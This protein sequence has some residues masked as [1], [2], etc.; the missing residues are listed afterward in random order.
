[1]LSEIEIDRN[2]TMGLEIPPMLLFGPKA[3]LMNIMVPVPVLTMLPQSFAVD[4]QRIRNTHP[5]SPDT[6]G[7]GGP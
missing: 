1:M 7:W 6:R 3:W 2:T 4:L 5:R